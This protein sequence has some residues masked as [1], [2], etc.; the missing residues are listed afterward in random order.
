MSRYRCPFCRTDNKPVTKRIRN[1]FSTIMEAVIAVPGSAI[2]VWGAIWI[3]SE[4]DNALLMAL[5]LIPLAAL[6]IG[7]FI[8]A[9]TMFRH[10]R[11]VCPDC[12]VR[13]G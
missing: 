7:L 9:E 3:I 5:G 6:W 11:Q 2:M 10:T 13:I 1:P 4:T 12:K 8:A